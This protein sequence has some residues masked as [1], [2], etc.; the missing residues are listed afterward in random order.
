[1]LK[2]AKSANKGHIG[3]A[4]SICEVVVAMLA[5]LNGIGSSE[6]DRAGILLSKGHASLAC[7]SA[8]Y[9]FGIISAE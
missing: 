8:L 2:A 6:N 5:S 3:S 9:K 4:L 7:H 1:M